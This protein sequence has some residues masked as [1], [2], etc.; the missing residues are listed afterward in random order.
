MNLDLYSDEFRDF[1][2]LKSNPDHIAAFKVARAAANRIQPWD[3]DFDPEFVWPGRLEFVEQLMDL[4]YDSVY[5]VFAGMLSTNS[6]L[7]ESANLIEVKKPVIVTS[8]PL[9]Y[10]D[11]KEITIEDIG[12][13]EMNGNQKYCL[14]EE[15]SFI[16]DNNTTTFNGTGRIFRMHTLP[17]VPFAKSDF[18]EMFYDKDTAEKYRKALTDFLRNKLNA[19]SA[20]SVRL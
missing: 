7:Y 14:C 12:W 6:H 20:L 9:I 1:K 10:S 8:N 16:Y 5:I 3:S 15:E 11:T 4:R 13:I 19:L 2:Y 18:T 17:V